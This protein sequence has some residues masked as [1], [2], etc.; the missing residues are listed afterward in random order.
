MKCLDGNVVRLSF[1]G[2]TSHL[3]YKKKLKN[4]TSV[5][6]REVYFKCLLVSV[7]VQLIFLGLF[8]S[9]SLDVEVERLAVRKQQPPLCSNTD[10]HKCP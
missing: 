8:L 7:G 6:R 4:K 2:K 9:H 5:F 3:S 10:M 1:Y